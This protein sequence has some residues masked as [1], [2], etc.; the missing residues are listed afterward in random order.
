[1]SSVTLAIYCVSFRCHQNIS[2]F[3]NSQ[4]QTNYTS[5]ARDADQPGPDFFSGK[6]QTASKVASASAGQ[7]HFRFLPLLLYFILAM[8]DSSKPAAD[9]A[10]SASKPQ[11]A[12]KPPNPVFKMMGRRTLSPLNLLFGS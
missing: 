3:E 5:T 1:M 9:A 7:V 2:R 11:A 10:T 6:L 4:K 8:A 12:P